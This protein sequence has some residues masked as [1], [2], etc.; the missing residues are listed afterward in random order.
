MDHR[1]NGSS[2]WVAIYILGN[3][4]GHVSLGRLA[5][6]LAIWLSAI[7]HSLEKARKQSTQTTAESMGA[8]SLLTHSNAAISITL[9]PLANSQDNSVSPRRREGHKDGKIGISKF[10]FVTFVRYKFLRIRSG[11]AFAIKT[12]RHS[13]LHPHLNL[14]PSRGKKPD[15][16]FAQLSYSMCSLWLKFLLLFLRSLRSPRLNFLTGQ[17]AK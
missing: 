11:Q 8:F 17:C 10:H 12:S 14:P 2:L 4:Y 13:D 16:A 6:P 1:T 9:S 15:G 7:C 5:L 3:E